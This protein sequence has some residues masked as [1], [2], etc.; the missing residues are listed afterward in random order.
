VAA[1]VSWPG[2]G[3]CPR[4]GCSRSRRFSCG[5]SSSRSTADGTAIR[6]G[7]DPPCARPRCCRLSLAAASRRAERDL[8]LSL[9]SQTN[10]RVDAVL[11]P[12]S[13]VLSIR[14]RTGRSDSLHDKHHPT[15]CDRRCD[16]HIRGGLLPND[17]RDS[18]RHRTGFVGQ[19]REYARLERAAGAL[20]Q[21]GR[22]VFRVQLGTRP[23]TCRQAASLGEV[24]EGARPAGQR[25]LDA[26]EVPLLRPTCRACQFNCVA[27]LD[28]VG[29][30]KETWCCRCAW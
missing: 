18:E 24:L 28:A 4:R 16:E 22:W 20:G 14:R 13:V 19:D 1:P 12:S 6:P 25:G 10:G 27:Q 29:S 5:S 21:R 30:L 8:L 3:R 2:L 7:L 9:P 23:A 26:L 15:K 17:R 11:G